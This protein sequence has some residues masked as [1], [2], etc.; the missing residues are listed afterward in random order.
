MLT[1]KNMLKLQAI[2]GVMELLSPDA[3]LGLSL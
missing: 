2:L 1:L 3:Q